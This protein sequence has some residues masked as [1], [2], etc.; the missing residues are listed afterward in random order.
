[1]DVLTGLSGADVLLGEVGNDVLAGGAGKDVLTGGAGQDVFVFDSR[2]NKTANVDRIEDFKVADDTLHLAKSVFTKMAKKGVIKSAEFY[3]GPKA[4]DRDDRLIYDK[5]T[6]A[7]YY[8]AD[9][10][11]AQAQI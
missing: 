1:N 8:D 6:G 11:G 9:G 2:P 5:K 4:H 10:T 3:Q 7:L